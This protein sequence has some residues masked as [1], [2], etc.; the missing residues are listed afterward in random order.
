MIGTGNTREEAYASLKQRFDDFISEGK[1]LP[2]PGT[3]M[4][5]QFAPRVR[6][7]LYHRLAEDFFPRIV[8]MD[9]RKV[10]I[11]DRSSLWDFPIEDA[12]AELTARIREA[13][14]VD[15]SDI[16]DGNLVSIFQRIEDSR[17]DIRE[18]TR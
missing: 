13:Y 16:E 12:P 5:L 11:T 6:V 3:R 9:Y 15:V 18:D 7:L 4:P 14:G 10:L 1:E 8:S 17:A 2:R